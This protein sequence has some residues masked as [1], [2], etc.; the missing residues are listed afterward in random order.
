MM[1]KL[2]LAAFA[3]ASFAIPKLA[4]AQQAGAGNTVVQ[5]TA[6]DPRASV[7]IQ[8]ATGVAAQ[9]TIT[10]PAIS[11]SCFYLVFFEQRDT[12]TVAPAL[13]A[14]TTTTTNLQGKTWVNVIPATT[15]VLGTPVA[16]YP[17]KPIK[18]AQC[19]L[20]TTIV[21]ATAV[22]SVT[23]NMSAGGYYAPF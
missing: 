15:G 18:A 20:A 17:S 23:Y 10:F 22:T 3:I 21:S 14:T 2:I 8:T 16:F 12:A 7:S 5:E 13:T 1:K 19:G 6:T 4:H 9:T 11:G